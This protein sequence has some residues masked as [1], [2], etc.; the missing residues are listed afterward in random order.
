MFTEDRSIK[1]RGQIYVTTDDSNNVEMTDKDI[2][3]IIGSSLIIGSMVAGVLI[4]N[5]VVAYVIYRKKL[6]EIDKWY[7]K[8]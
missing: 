4:V 6:N 7:G 5:I 2:R 8:I 3:M 1:E